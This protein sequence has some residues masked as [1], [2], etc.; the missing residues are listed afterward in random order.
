M[1]FAVIKTG[2]KQYQVKTGDIVTI[3]KITGDYKEG[4]IV[5]F[6]EVLLIDSGSATTIGEP[7][8]AGAKVTGTL[9]KIGRH[10]KINVIRYKQ[11]SRYFKK[12]GHRQEFFKVKI[13]AI[14]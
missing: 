14:K 2:G 13:D 3:E 1:E 6:N 7:T 9:T 12:N 11:K 4:D 8:I 5:N 10:P